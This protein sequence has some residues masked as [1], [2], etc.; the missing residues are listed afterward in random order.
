L[1]PPGYGDY[2]LPRG[3][4]GL[5][6]EEVTANQRLRLIGAASELLVEERL[7]GLT[8]RA[9]ARRAGVSSHTFY[10]HFTDVDDVLTAS[11]AL[12]SRLLFETLAA[13]CA[14]GEGPS[15]R[16][17]AL[18]AALSL[19]A[20]EAWLIALMRIELAVAIPGVAADRERLTRWLRALL[21]GS[22]SEGSGRGLD[23]ALA[24]ALAVGVDRLDAERTAA[25]G[26]VAELGSLLP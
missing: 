20:E 24:A 18:S 9:I 6:R 7:E 10:E 19:G 2:R 15:G 25:A 26:I 16:R 8:S 5:S 1:S 4:H 22:E 17:E 21:G 11:Y 14:E 12:A 23:A 3:R 13:A